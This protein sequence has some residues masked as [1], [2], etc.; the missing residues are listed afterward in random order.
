MKKFIVERDW[1]QFHTPKNLSAKIASEAGEL[2]DKF[3]WLTSEQSFQEL[4]NNR[5]EIEDEVGDI[6]ICLLHFCN[7]ANIDLT[8]AMLTKLQEV[9]AK[10][11]VEKFKGIATK[12]NKL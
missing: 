4:Q 3:V 10:Y 1:Q 6:A 5:Q 7:A 12:Y 8:S 11:P 9:K 2:L